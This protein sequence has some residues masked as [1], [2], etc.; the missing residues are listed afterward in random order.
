MRI[1]VVLAVFDACFAGFM[2]SWRPASD[3]MSFFNLR[4]SALAAWFTCCPGFA[5]SPVSSPLK[6]FLPEL[7]KGEFLI[8]THLVWLC[9]EVVKFGKTPKD[10]YSSA[11]QVTHPANYESICGLGEQ[12]DPAPR[13]QTYILGG[14][15]TSNKEFPWIVSLR[16]RRERDVLSGHFCAGS[17]VSETAVV[18]AAH[19][20]ER[21]TVTASGAVPGA[22]SQE[23][24]KF[25]P[26]TPENDV[27]KFVQAVPTPDSCRDQICEIVQMTP[28][29][30]KPDSTA[31]FGH[32]LLLHRCLVSRSNLV[33]VYRDSQGWLRMKLLAQIVIHPE[34]M[35]E[36]SDNDIAVLILQDKLDF[37]GVDSQL[38]PICLPHPGDEIQEWPT[39]MVA[40]WGTLN[41]GDRRTS[42]ILL[43]TDVQIIEQLVCKRAYFNWNQ[44]TNRMFCA[45]D[46]EFGNKGTCMGDSGGPLMCFRDDRRY[47]LSGVTSWGVNCGLRNYPGVFIDVEK[48]LGFIVKH[49]SITR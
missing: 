37:H 39:C 44:V 18:T 26:S 14:V 16:L 36:T 1:V 42:R 33:V 11:N 8:M 6:G 47:Q 19:C 40:G 25:H 41:F 29:R 49:A 17:I 43:K 38:R 28:H 23:L 3:G 15:G 4:R 10:S 2:V 48:F 9:D 24:L 21:R 7:F 5:Y 35:T 20:V 34:Y 22:S 12:D 13:I 45:G 32:L 30:D 27:D 46:Y 31:N